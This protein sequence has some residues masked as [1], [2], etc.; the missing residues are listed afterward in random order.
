MDFPN[1]DLKQV[2]HGLKI[3][4]GT[5]SEVITTQYD[6]KGRIEIGL[7]QMTHYNISREDRN[8]FIDIEKVNPVRNSSG[9]LN[10]ALRG[11][12]PYGAEPGIILKSN[13]DAEQG[14]IISNG[15]K[16]AVEIKEVK[17][18]SAPPSPPAVVASATEKTNKAKEII[19]FSLE[20]KKDHIDFNI[21]ADGKVENY[22]LFKLDG[23]PRLVLDIW[24]VGT[25]YPK[26]S[27]RISNPFIK[28]VR[29]GQHQD[30][31]RLVFDSSKPQLPAYQI[32]RIGDRLVI[33]L[34]NVPQPSEPQIL[35]QEKGS[36]KLSAPKLQLASS[37]APAVKE[38]VASPSA[39]VP[40]KPVRAK[41]AL[42]EIDFKQINDKSRIAVT[43]SG[44]PQFETYRVSEKAIAID[45]KN[46]FAPK[47]LQRRMNTS[48]FDSAVNYIDIKNV[49]NDVKILVTLREEMPY[50]ANK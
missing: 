25:Q 31:L 39:V 4:N 46:A 14:G 1:I 22:N 49:K 6:D 2:K 21:L 35:L 3:E 50:E 10:P 33:S 44:D 42:K 13:P 20:E 26:K 28:E 41:I 30:K 17:K 19:D 23:P 40:A 9:A 32:N 11:G 16:K 8:V 45:I 38:K 12:A 24:E 15:V 34:G 47:H 5:I 36:E 18:E 48:E 27:I 7:L 37:T 29:I 43:L